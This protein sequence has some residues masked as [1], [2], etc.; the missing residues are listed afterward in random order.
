MP[1]AIVLTF[2]SATV[3]WGVLLI[4][5]QAINILFRIVPLP[6]AVLTCV[7]MFLIVLCCAWVI[8]PPPHLAHTIPEMKISPRLLSWLHTAQ[9]GQDTERQG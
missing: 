5:L 2:P 6:V 4:N 8:Y 7:A 3:I 1:L 9:R